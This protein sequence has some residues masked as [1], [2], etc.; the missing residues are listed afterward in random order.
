MNMV[1]NVSFYLLM[2]SVLI[3]TVK[4]VL[5]TVNIIS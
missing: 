2:H 4:D 5:H 1:P 3:C